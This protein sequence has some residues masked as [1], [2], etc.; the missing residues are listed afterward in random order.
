[1]ARSAKQKAARNLRRGSRPVFQFTKLPAEL[2]LLVLCRCDL[3]SFG[4]LLS[5]SSY[6]RSLC[7]QH[8]EVVIQGSLSEIPQPVAGLLHVATA[9][10]NINDDFDGE[11]PLELLE[12]VN[13]NEWPL[14]YSRFLHSGDD[15][16]DYMRGLVDIYV[17]VD[18]AADIVAQGM[19]AAMQIYI[20]P[21][22]AVTPVLLSVAEHTRLVC[23]L[24]IVKIYYQLRSKLVPNGGTSVGDF[25][26]AFMQTLAPWQIAQGSSVEGFL[27]SCQKSPGGLYDDIIGKRYT[28]C[29][30]L[31]QKSSYL[32]TYSR[33]AAV[34]MDKGFVFGQD[35]S[36]PRYSHAAA[37]EHRRIG[38]RESLAGRVGYAQHPAMQL[39]NHGWMMYSTIS[40]YDMMRRDLVWRV[41]MLFWDQDRLA[42]WGMVDASDVVTLGT[43]TAWR[44]GYMRRRDPYSL[45]QD[46]IEDMTSPYLQIAEFARAHDRDI[47]ESS[48]RGNGDN[49]KVG[50]LLCS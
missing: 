26:T 18:V 7:I 35:K 41:G 12:K 43:E 48:G 23:A 10:H 14:V 28:C 9:L 32:R 6:V 8:P 19:N 37:E 21:Q 50:C 16:L 11:R 39:R 22:V 4:R 34:D 15:V 2:Q 5:V 45:Q 31:L 13:S 27:D 20:D 24:L 49:D 3:I 1:M 47:L 30:C 25:A 42:S 17:E 38:R 46:R 40:P 33:A 36:F 29:E 44:L